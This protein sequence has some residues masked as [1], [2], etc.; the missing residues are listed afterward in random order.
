MQ[1]VNFSEQAA[2]KGGFEHF[3][4]KEI[5]E[6][7][8][9]LSDTI[10]PHIKDDLPNLSIPNFSDDKILSFK[11]I[12]IVACGTAMHAGLVGK[13][14]IES[15]A[16]IPVEVNIA[17]EFRY[18]N[19]ILSKDD[20]VIVISQSGETADTL[21]ALKLA[22]KSGVFTLAV[23]NIKGSSIEREADATF[24]TNAG[25]EI[26]VAS[27]KA[28]AVQ[29]AFMYL[30]SLKL[31]LIYETKTKSETKELTQILKETP[32]KVSETIEYLNPICKALAKDNI[33][34]DTLFF[35]GRGMDYA[36]SVEGSLKLKEISYIHSE[37]YAAGELKHG[38]IS[39]ITE[40]TPVVAIAT[41]T[42][43]I[44]KMI[45]NV[46]EIKA[47]GGKVIFVTTENEIPRD[48][49]DFLVPLVKT[50]DFFTPL[51]LGPFIQL[52]AYYTALFRGCDVDKPRNLAKSVTVE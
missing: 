19:P 26:S 33:K 43:L 27:T 6:E 21:A 15:L 25:P 45:S 13:T 10:F 18:S 22:K 50:E 7:P 35:I 23:V 1:K 24:L 30:L 42:N 40:G 52:F 2:E 17:S 34:T 46:K 5:Y 31:A 38:T 41:Q 20:L 12:H 48:A 8:K 11:K 29:C 32:Q 51:I 28:Y 3:M 36:L 44:E 39:L 14:L 49:Y 16:R 37:G 9:A 4:L 47:R